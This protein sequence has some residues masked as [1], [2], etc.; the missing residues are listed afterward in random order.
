MGFLPGAGYLDWV[1]LLGLTIVGNL[2]GGLVLVTVLRLL[3]V[4]NKVIAEPT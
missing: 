1:A 3:Q 4:P 2:V